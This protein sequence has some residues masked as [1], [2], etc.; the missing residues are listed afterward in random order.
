MTFVEAFYS[1]SLAISNCDSAQFEKTRLKI[2]RHPYEP[3]QHLFARVVAYCH[4]FATGLECGPGMFD[5]REPTLFTKE[6]TGELQRVIEVGDLDP[7]KL[8]KLLRR[9][10]QGEFRVYLYDRA[11]VD[12][13]SQALKGSTTNWI[14]AVQ[15]LWI[16]PAFLEELL[17]Y[18]RSSSKWEITIVDETLYLSIDGAGREMPIET[19]VTSISMWDEFQSYLRRSEQSP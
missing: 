10:P 6:V 9:Y 3:L 17:P 2:P 5:L 11:Q 14:E 16:E 8:K 15:F 12:R 4:A 1:F 13:L 19:R 7:Q 18:E